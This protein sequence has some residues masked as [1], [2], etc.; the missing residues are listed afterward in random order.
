MHS[1]A[2]SS[3]Y[4]P[5][6]LVDNILD[7]L[8]DDYQSLSSCSLVCRAWLPS[9][10]LH[11]FS[12][13]SLKAA[14]PHAPSIYPPQDRCRRL[15]RMLLRSPEII[16]CIRELEICEGSGSSPHHP[17][18]RST[19]WVTTERSLT[20]LLQI[21]THLR[22]LDFSSQT[23]I[24]WTT[25]PRGFQEA[26]CKI[27][28]LPS[29]TYVRLHSWSFPLAS[30]LSTALS[31]CRNLNALALSSTTVS[32]EHDPDF[33]EQD[34]EQSEVPLSLTHNT[35]L[36]VL[37]LDHVHCG[38]LEYWLLSPRS[39]LNVTRLRELRVAHFHHDP[40]V[41]ERLLQAIGHSLEHFHLKPGSWDVCSF[42]LGLNAG[43][44]SIRLTLDEPDTAIAWATTLLSNV[45]AC[46]TLERVGL[47][48]FVDLK[49]LDGWSGLDSLLVELASLRQVEIGLFASPSNAEFL[50]VKNEFSGLGSRGLLRLYQLG[51]KSQRSSRQLAPRINGYES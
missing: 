4:L 26:L 15:Y 22:R 7:H 50:K 37:T 21:L 49:K 43:L 35:R 24:Y 1:S 27:L 12:K 38:Y 2:L 3:A 9:S 14:A 36:E 20:H 47:E 13:I 6:E 17:D 42:D 23:V 34:N 45:A 51:I 28:S 31:R 8:H 39:V 10:R 33:E 48:F 46:T 30:S 44:R 41:I 16:P 32:E 5:Q 29:L 11:L 19:T 40:L 25:L 18:A